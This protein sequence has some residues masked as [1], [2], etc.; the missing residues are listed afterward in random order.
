MMAIVALHQKPQYIPVLAQWFH[1]Q[2]GYLHPGR[3]MEDIIKELKY[4]AKPN[5]GLP[6][7]IV[8]EIHGEAVGTA[9]LIEHDMPELEKSRAMTP[10]LAS[11]YV[12]PEYRGQG[13]GE[14]LLDAMEEQAKNLGYQQIYLYTPDQKSWYEKYD[15]KLLEHIIYHKREVD[16]M[17]K[18]IG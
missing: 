11:V 6:S 1:H 13:V 16:I 18:W 3:L 4:S 14:Q 17:S 5:K 10:W 12:T 8:L 2:W 9:S 15:W 7:I